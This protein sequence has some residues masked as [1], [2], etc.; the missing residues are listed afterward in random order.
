MT[1]RFRQLTGFADHGLVPHVHAV[2]I[3]DRDHGTPVRRRKRARRSNCLSV[4]PHGPGKCQQAP[5]RSS[6]MV[7]SA[8]TYAAGTKSKAILTRGVLLLP[9]GIV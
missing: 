3:A 1:A 9:N 6:F 7:P 8:D 5:N 4:N 2:K